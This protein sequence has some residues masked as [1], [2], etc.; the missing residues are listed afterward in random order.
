MS[1]KWNPLSNNFDLVDDA[2]TLVTGPGVSTDN[3]IVRFDGTSGVLIQNS[4]ATISD[5]GILT[6]DELNLVTQLGVTYGGTGRTSATAYSVICGG[7][8]ATG[9]YQSVASVGAA[10]EVLTSNGAGALPTWQASGS[11]SP[12]TTK[13]DLYGFST[14]DARLPVGTDTYVLTA[15]SSEALGVKWAAGVSVPVA[16][17]DG[18]TGQTTYATGDILY[19]DATDSLSKLSAAQCPNIL[20]MDDT[21]VPSWSDDISYWYDDFIYQSTTGSDHYPWARGAN[22][23]GTSSQCKIGIAGHPGIWELATGTTNAGKA[24]IQK[25]SNN[26]S[27]LILGSGVIIVDFIIHIPVLSTASEEFIFSCGVTDFYNVFGGSAI[28]N[29]QVAFIYDRT[30]STNWLAVTRSGATETVASGGSSVAVD[31]NWTHARIVINADA[32]SVEF[33]IDGT[34]L[35]TSTTNIPS[36]DLGVGAMIEKSVGTTERTLEI[37]CVRFYNKLT[38]SR[39]SS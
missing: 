14:V 27:P 6:A 12:L 20:F 2:A 9:A 28:T 37:D 10:G 1:T 21:G 7:T 5:A 23:T 11:S 34:S 18:G 35:G 3:A 32:T 4:T 15:D 22:G 33:F 31:T 13:G 38:T 29:D 19:S 36:S 30:Q 24:V 25:G 8:T 26:T 39:F 17:T 16:E